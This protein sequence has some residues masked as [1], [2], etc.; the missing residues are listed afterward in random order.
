MTI[1]IFSTQGS[2]DIY[3]VFYYF[4]NT[5]II[6]INPQTKTKKRKQNDCKTHPLK[7]ALNYKKETQLQKFKSQKKK[8][9]RKK[10]KK[11]IFKQLC[12]KQYIN[13]TN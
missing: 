13:I 5:M 6:L 12:S 8:E 11:K 10:Q 4:K 1:F 9:T 3:Y 2:V 7:K